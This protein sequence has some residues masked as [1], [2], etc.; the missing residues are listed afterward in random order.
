MEQKIG[1]IIALAVFAVI[2][3]VIFFNLQ[4]REPQSVAPR[5]VGSTGSATDQSAAAASDMAGI[6]TFIGETERNGMLITAV[7]LPPIQME[8]LELPQHSDVIHLEAD[9]HGLAG[10]QNGFGLGAWIPY[11]TVTYEIKPHDSSQ[12]AI[13][14]EFLPMV[15]KDGPHYGATIEMPAAGK[16]TLTYHIDNP[17]KKGFGRH[18]DPITGVGPW[19]DAFDVTFEFDY[20]GSKS[21]KVQS[22]PMPE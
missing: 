19:W 5:L 10:N 22:D 8:G 3:L 21:A 6:E 14:G 2:G 11:L 15:A 17:G 4:S 12:E 7:W 13:T 16:Y 18:S 9:I 20:P 1:G